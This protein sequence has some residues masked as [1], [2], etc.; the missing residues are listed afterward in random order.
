MESTSIRVLDVTVLPYR[1]GRHVPHA[2]GDV[3][4][5]DKLAEAIVRAIRS[6]DRLLTAVL[7]PC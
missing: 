1:N 7:E 4:S 5:I 6:G 3:I 2:P